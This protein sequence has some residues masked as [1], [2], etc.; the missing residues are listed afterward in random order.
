MWGSNDGARTSR[1]LRTTRK[2]GKTATVPLAPRTAEAVEDYA[3][4]RTTDHCS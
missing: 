3:G 4:D 1:V 2:G